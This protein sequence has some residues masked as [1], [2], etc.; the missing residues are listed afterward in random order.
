MH[1]N[2]PNTRDPPNILSFVMRDKKS[3]LKDDFE[4]NAYY[5]LSRLSAS[6]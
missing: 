6:R 1:K 3:E 4:N 2:V 5:S